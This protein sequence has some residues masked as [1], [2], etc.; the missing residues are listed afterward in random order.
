M[1]SPL[2]I[3]DSNALMESAKRYYAFDIA[4]GFWD[5]LLPHIETGTLVTID[6]VCAEIEKGKDELCDWTKANLKPRQATTD[7]QNVIAEF[8]SMMNWVQANAQFLDSA[9]AEFASVADGWLMAYASSR[10]ATVV[11]HEVFVKDIKRKVP[12]PNV[13]MQFGIEYIGIFELL[14]RLKITLK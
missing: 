3:L 10:N 14:R 1:A 11:T 8:S 6:R 4:P 5:G 13:C 7:D 12:I 2:Y 9:K